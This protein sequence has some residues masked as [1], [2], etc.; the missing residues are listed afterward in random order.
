M[1]ELTEFICDPEMRLHGYAPEVFDADAG[2]SDRAFNYA[3]ANNRDCLGWRTDFRELERTLGSEMF[4][5]RVLACPSTAP[6]AEVE[7]LFLFP[8]VFER[9]TAASTHTAFSKA[10]T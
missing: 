7:R 9:V 2:L 6:P 3:I 10:R 8:G 1:A 5:K 4:R